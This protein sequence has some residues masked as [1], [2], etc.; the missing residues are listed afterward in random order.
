METS[1]RASR[2]GLA[3]MQSI[4]AGRRLLAGCSLKRREGKI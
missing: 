3:K 4:I 2:E 1:P